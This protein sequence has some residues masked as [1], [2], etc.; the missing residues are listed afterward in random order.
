MRR[1]TL[2]LL[3]IQLV[4]WA[5]LLAVSYAIARFIVPFE[6]PSKRVLTGILRGAMGVALL[7]GWLA[8][9]YLI[10][11]TAYKRLSSVRRGRSDGA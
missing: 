7:A 1:S 4:S 8:G 9:W 3:F 11:Q 5:M 2:T 10:F 6:L